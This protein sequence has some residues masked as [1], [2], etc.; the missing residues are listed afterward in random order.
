MQTV[1]WQEDKLSR[2]FAFLPSR[3]AIS[4]AFCSL[5]S[6]KF[7]LCWLL[8]WLCSELRRLYCCWMRLYSVS[9]SLAWAWNKLTFYT[10]VM[11]INFMDK[12]TTNFKLIKCPSDAS[13]QNKSIFFY[14]NFSKQ[15]LQAQHSRN[16]V[17]KDWFHWQIVF[18]P[19]WWILIPIL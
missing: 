2:A 12:K 14:I 5:N 8:T 18:K 6:W 9:S 16:W 7:L 10:M 13:Q 3:D 15:I 11:G 19:H 1:H 4:L 17:I